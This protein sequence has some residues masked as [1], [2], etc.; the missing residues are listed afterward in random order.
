MLRPPGAWR[1]M[2]PDEI[3]AV[4]ASPAAAA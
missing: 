3:A 1:L 2:T 4:F